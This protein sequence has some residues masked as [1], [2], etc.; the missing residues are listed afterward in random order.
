MCKRF[1]PALVAGLTLVFAGCDFVGD[2]DSVLIPVS[3]VEVDALPLDLDGQA[4][5]ADSPP[6]ILIEIQNAA[7]RAVYRSEPLMD[8]DLTAG[9][10][11]FE[12]PATEAS[13]PT[14]PLFVTVYESGGDFTLDRRMR[15]SEAF[16]VAEIAS[17]DVVEL[18]D[19]RGRGL[20]VRLE[21][22]APA[23]E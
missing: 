17:E 6:D 12:I 5:D 7:G 4:W 2:G 22:A 23:Q 10:F 13:N 3:A 15:T 14:L 18:G 20:E 16:R 1:A 9:P 8:V 11:R 19:I 21:V